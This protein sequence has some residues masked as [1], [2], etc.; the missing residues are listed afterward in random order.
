MKQVLLKDVKKGEFFRLVNSE[1]APLW[2]RD[3]FVRGKRA[4]CC[5]KYDD[6][7]HC[8]NYSRTLLVYV[9]D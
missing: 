7:N 8:H 4:Y 9:E 6:I 5:F 1:A 2:V 3:F